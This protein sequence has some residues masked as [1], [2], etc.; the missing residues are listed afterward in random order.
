MCPAYTPSTEKATNDIPHCPFQD[1]PCPKID[2]M[3]DEVD[4]VKAMVQGMQR[5]LYLIAGIL[6]CELGVTII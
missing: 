1:A 3:E 4:S 6:V 2:R 5:T